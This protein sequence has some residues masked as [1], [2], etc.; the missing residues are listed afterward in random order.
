M[1]YNN[2]L[3]SWCTR[4]ISTLMEFCCSVWSQITN[5]LM[6]YQLAL[7][8]IKLLR[9]CGLISR[10]VL[11]CNITQNKPIHNIQHYGCPPWPDI[12]Q[13]IISCLQENPTKRPT[14]SPTPPVMLL[15]L[16]TLQAQEVYDR[17]C[18]AELIGLKIVIPTHPELTVEAFT[19]RVMTT[20]LIL[21]LH[22]VI[23]L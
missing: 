12:E 23:C 19:F 10:D 21:L 11:W 16:T 6:I 22:H 4:L 20:P 13:L 15:L 14:V 1:W 9:R 2:C 3:M 8:K 18:T 5:H 17:L 7:I